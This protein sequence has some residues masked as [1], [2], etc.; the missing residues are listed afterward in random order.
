MKRN[1]LYA[2]DIAS[3]AGDATYT[4][5]SLVI[6]VSDPRTRVLSLRPYATCPAG[7]SG[8]LSFTILSRS[9]GVWDSLENPL[10]V[11]HLI[12]EAS[13]VAS[14]YFLLGV[15]DLDAIKID[16]IVNGDATHTL[17][18]V[19]CIYTINRLEA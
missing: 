13:K 4:T 16:Q 8:N 19:N 10:K 18:L 17:T 14:G 12:L 5:D 15:S 6:N 11:L 7:T 3:I 1:T 9:S 2:S